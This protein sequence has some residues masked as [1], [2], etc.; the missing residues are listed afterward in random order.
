MKSISAFKSD[1][2]TI[3]GTGYFARHQ[4]SHRVLYARTPWCRVA[5]ASA[6]VLLSLAFVLFGAI[7]NAPG[8]AFL[9][10]VGL[11]GMAWKFRPRKKASAPKEEER[12]EVLS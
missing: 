10:L 7:L 8:V 4:E 5:S 2:F 11:V 3:D 1:G 12:N 9:G 6:I